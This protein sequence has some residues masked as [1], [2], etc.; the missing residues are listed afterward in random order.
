MARPHVSLIRTANRKEAPMSKKQRV[1]PLV[2]ARARQLGVDIRAVRGSSPDGR[3][4]MADV[5]AHARQRPRQSAQ[6]VT[7]AA[8]AALDARLANLEAKGRAGSG[9]RP[10]VLVHARSQ[11]DSNRIV[12]VDP[13][14]RNPLADD[15][16]QVSATTFNAAARVS[17]PPTLFASGD[18]P[19]YTASGNDPEALLDLPWQ[20]RHA[21]AR[22]DQKTW[23]RLFE[24]CG[25]GV[26]DADVA[27]MFVPEARDLANDDYRAR[28]SA[29]LQ[30]R[31]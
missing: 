9:T 13:R 5:E 22:A 21:A 15:Y 14:A 31:G 20:L 11:F 8:L 26:A 7:R 27:M 3:V 30:G 19:P 2:A 1:A 4:L 6:P 16:K 18:V 17:S 25:P 23:A 29:W 12:Q 10:A 24:E 28:F